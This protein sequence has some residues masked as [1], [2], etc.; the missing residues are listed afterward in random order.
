M[1]LRIKGNKEIF[2]SNW[3]E[4]INMISKSNNLDRS[5]I[6]SIPTLMY[7]VNYTFRLKSNFGTIIA[8]LL[9]DKKT[10]KGSSIDEF[11]NEKMLRKMVTESLSS[12]DD[13]DDSYFREN[14]GN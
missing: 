7:D 5:E 10:D 11:G 3:F 4:A 13:D 6:D 8:E 14:Y 12:D 2:V 1:R 9:N